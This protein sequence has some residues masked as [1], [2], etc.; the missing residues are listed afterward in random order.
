M[1]PLSCLHTYLL[2]PK[3]RNSE[4]ERA[5]ESADR[6]PLPRSPSPARS[7]SQT[8]IRTPVRISACAN[9]ALTI[10]EGISA[11][12]ALD[13]MTKL[14]R[15]LKEKSALASE[16]LHSQDETIKELRQAL[17]NAYSVHQ[18]DQDKLK[19]ALKSL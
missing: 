11:D 4:Q 7:S 12:D 2:Y 16:Q 17:E 10:P 6:V 18:Q 13:T 14:G 1:L 9:Q 15:I 8:P 3:F 19:K 5:D